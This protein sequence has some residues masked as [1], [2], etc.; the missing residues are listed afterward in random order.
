MFWDWGWTWK[1]LTIIIA[2]YGIK[3]L[4]DYIG[5]SI[6]ILDSIFQDT[7]VGIYVTSSK[8][9]TPDEQF[10]IS[11]DNLVVSNVVKIV[12]D[13]T[14]GL[15]LAGGSQTIDSWTIGKIYDEKNLTG[16]FQSGG[17]LSST[18]PKTESLGGGPHNGYFER[19]KPQYTELTSNDFLSA[20]TG[21]KGKARLWTFISE[22][23]GG[24]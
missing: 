3:M 17:A 11:I 13:N 21:A 9:G 20:I 16:K 1:S 19:T 4:G 22:I 15:T 8:G 12:S 10:S 24:G 5:G 7:L 18:H 6:H 14:A 2:D 23:L